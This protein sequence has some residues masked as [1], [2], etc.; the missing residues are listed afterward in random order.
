[1]IFLRPD[2]VQLETE[3]P[4]WADPGRAG[5]AQRGRPTRLLAIL[6]LQSQIDC[7]GLFY[8]DTHTHTHFLI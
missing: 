7:F 4:S 6:L 5:A 3:G 1:M 2:H 8:L